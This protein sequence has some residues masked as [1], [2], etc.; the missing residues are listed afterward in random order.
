MADSNIRKDVIFGNDATTKQT[1]SFTGIELGGLIRDR[2]PLLRWRLQR[3]EMPTKRRTFS[4][5]FQWSAGTIHSVA[6]PLTTTFVAARQT[7]GVVQRGYRM[8]LV[9]VA[10]KWLR[11]LFQLTKRND[12]VCLGCCPHCRSLCG[13]YC[14][15][16]S[17]RIPYLQPLFVSVRVSGFELSHFLSI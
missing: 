4:I 17:R 6:S 9:G 3:Q 11:F 16:G 2:Q 15:F 5:C 13:V 8:R 10:P 1:A 12:H 7:F 14:Q